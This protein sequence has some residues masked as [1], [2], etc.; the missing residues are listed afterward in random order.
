METATTAPSKQN[1]T[2]KGAVL[3]GNA[4]KSGNLLTRADFGVHVTGRVDSLSE[5][6][7]RSGK[8][9][10]GSDYSFYQQTLTLA[11]GGQMVEVVFRADSD[12][13]GPLA[14]FDLDEAVRIKVEN[15][16]VFNGRVSF[17]VAK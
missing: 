14:A 6:Q 5:V 10:K 4:Q 16:R 3:P 12:P 7:H 2:S 8:T 15:P 17:D 13:A 9:Q 1:D 11:M